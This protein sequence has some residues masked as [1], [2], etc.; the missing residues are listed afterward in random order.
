MRHDTFWPHAGFDREPL[1]ETIVDYYNKFNAVTV[2]GI[3]G[4]ILE[5]LPNVF[6]FSPLVDEQ[7]VVLLAQ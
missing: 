2:P 7:G 4:K 1:G 3:D 6:L 5:G